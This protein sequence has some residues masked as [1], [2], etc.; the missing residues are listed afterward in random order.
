MTSGA[1]RRLPTMASVPG[2]IFKLLACGVACKT[3][4]SGDRAFRK[5]DVKKAAT[6]SAR[7]ARQAARLSRGCAPL[8]AIHDFSMSAC[9]A[10]ADAAARA[11]P[12]VWLAWRPCR[13]FAP[14]TVPPPCRS[15]WPYIVLAYLPSCRLFGASPDKHHRHRRYRAVVRRIA[16]WHL[17][18]SIVA[19]A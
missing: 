15:S 2:G 3:Q 14:A 13:Y 6:T 12:G 11:R 7:L 4:K 9:S 5:Y 17:L 19:W 16:R 18:I 10:C 1:R 8:C